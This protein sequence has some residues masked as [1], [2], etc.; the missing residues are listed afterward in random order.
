MTL[1]LNNDNTLQERWTR[2]PAPNST[3]VQVG[4]RWLIEHSTSGAWSWAWGHGHGHAGMC[5]HGAWACRH[6]VTP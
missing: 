3:L 2:T 6:G 4:F 5:R 1:K